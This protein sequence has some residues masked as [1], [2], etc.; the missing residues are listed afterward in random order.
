[1]FTTLGHKG[2]ANQNDT[3]TDFTSPQKE[4]Q[5]S[6]TRTTNAGEDARVWKRKPLYTLVGME[7]RADTVEI[8]NGD[9]SKN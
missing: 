4:W 6:G 5:S 2:N 7:I 9:S 8:T 1:M 3:E